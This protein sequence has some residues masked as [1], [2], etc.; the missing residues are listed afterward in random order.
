MFKNPS[1][2]HCQLLK[3]KKVNAFDE[4]FM[5]IRYAY[6]VDNNRWI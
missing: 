4:Q 2:F 5:T 3:V 1:I 6:F